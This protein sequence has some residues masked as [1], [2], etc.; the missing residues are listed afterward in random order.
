MLIASILFFLL[1]LIFGIG[2]ESSMPEDQVAIM[3][4]IRFLDGLGVLFLVI[5]LVK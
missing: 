2:I 4:A 3:K 1:A 5:W